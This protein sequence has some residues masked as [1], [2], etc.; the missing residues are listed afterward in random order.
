MTLCDSSSLEDK[1]KLSEFY[2]HKLALPSMNLWDPNVV[3]GDM[4]LMAMASWLNHEE[5]KA[6]EVWNVMDRELKEPIMIRAE[7]ED[8][9]ALIH[10][11]QQL[12]NNSWS[13]PYYIDRQA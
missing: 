5:K 1:A 10:A 6:A 3:V 11:H 13:L 9:S 2:L 8:P 4:Q 12:A 7:P